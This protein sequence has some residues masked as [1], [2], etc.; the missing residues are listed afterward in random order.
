M[1]G[2]S[3]IGWAFAL[4]PL[5]GA[6]IFFWRG[7]KLGGLAFVIAF[8]VVLAGVSEKRLVLTS[9]MVG[10]TFERDADLRLGSK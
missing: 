10:I 7:N 6:A 9:A 4:I 5:A 3:L 2:I 8:I 1:T